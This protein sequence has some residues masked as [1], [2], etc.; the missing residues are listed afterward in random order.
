[1]RNIVK[2]AFFAALTLGFAACD[3]DDTPVEGAKVHFV[4]R[5]NPNQV[6]LNNLGQPATMPSNHAAQ[7]PTYNKISAHYIELSP[8]MY[9]AIGGGAVVYHAPETTT[10]GTNAINFDSAIVIAP[11]TRMLSVPIKDI[12]AG[13]YSYLRASILYQNYDISFRT[14]GINGTGTMASLVGF[15]TYLRN[16]QIK[17]ETIAVN[18]NKLQ[19]FWAFETFGMTFQGQAPAGATTV[20]NP[21]FATSPIP[22]GSCLVTGEFAS[23]LTITGDETQDVTVVISLSTNNSFE[24]RDNGDGIFDPQVDTV[25]DMGLRGMIPSV[26]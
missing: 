16:L 10:G 7:S 1:M 17:D 12:A 19:G 4:I 18:S 21:I 3:R 22:A 24:W 25:V 13:S 5:T 11:N 6:R 8:T 26:E 15:N 20:P 14:Q 23:P 9:T 2:T